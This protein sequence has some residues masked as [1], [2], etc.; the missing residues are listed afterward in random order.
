MNDLEGYREARAADW[1]GNRQQLPMELEGFVTGLT[2]AATGHSRKPA[3]LACG[4]CTLFVLLL[5]SLGALEPLQYGLTVNW[6]TRQVDQKTLYKG[7]RHFIG[8][9]NSF[10]A[11]PSTQV[12]VLF[13]EG[14]GGYG[15]LVTRTKDGLSLTLQLAF[16]YQ[17]DEQKLGELYSM[18]NM[19]Y[20]PLF[21]RNARDVLLKAAADYE[22][23]Q[24]W[25]EREKI[26][27]E[28][29]ALLGQRLEG[30]YARCG[31]LQVLVIDLP[32]EF[33][34]SIV[35][36]QVMEQ[37]QKTKQN[38]QQARRIEADTTVLKA[39]YARNVTVTKNGADALYSQTIRIAEAEA[40]QRLVEIEA[41]AMQEVQKIL[42]L[43]TEAMVL[44]QQFMAYASLNNASFVF[45]LGN[46]MLTLPS[47]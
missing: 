2:S 46:A 39:S 11:F 19:Q 12:T 8:P 13:A 6:V 42:G 36:T 3:A 31:G 32:Q 41:N 22:A 15:P 44:Y 9:W 18:A 16:Q 5:M 37:M 4:S 40:N 27:H 33:E 20:E 21:V 10:V 23:F 47:I 35:Q 17:V 7:G 25:Q 24:Y 28:M 14:D 38:D 45:G 26:G 1:V 29:K 34:T 43:S 30:L